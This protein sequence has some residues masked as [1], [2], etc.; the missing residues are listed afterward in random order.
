M[1]DFKK[2]LENLKKIVSA[3]DENEMFQM[4]A[5][6]Q[7]NFNTVQKEWFQ[8]SIE[9]ENVEAECEDYL[10]EII[11]YVDLMILM[12]QKAI[13]H[14]SLDKIILLFSDDWTD[15]TEPYIYMEFDSSSWTAVI[16]ELWQSDI[17][18]D[19]TMKQECVNLSEMVWDEYRPAIDAHQLEQD[20]ERICI[21]LRSEYPS[22]EVGFLITEKQ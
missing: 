6:E 15:G 14:K 20:A 9:Q 8:S 7:E 19:R 22:A 17:N 3:K 1:D 12:Y 16:D 11:R 13:P 2:A 5:A 10:H 21:H 4:F 18:F